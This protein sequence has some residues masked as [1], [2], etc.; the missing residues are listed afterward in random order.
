M[1][2]FMLHLHAQGDWKA[3]QTCDHARGIDRNSMH[4]ASGKGHK[5]KPPVDLE[6]PMAE[7]R[8]LNLCLGAT[9]DVQTV[10]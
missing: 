3:V 9:A 10:R 1:D 4:T 5:V 8:V 2:L 6:W 7:H